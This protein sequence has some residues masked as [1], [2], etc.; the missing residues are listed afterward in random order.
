[1][2]GKTRGNIVAEAIRGSIE[3]IRH[4]AGS[5]PIDQLTALHWL[6]KTTQ[7]V[8]DGLKDA[9]RQDALS[10]L[11][12]DQKVSLTGHLGTT[13]VVFMRP[14]IKLTPSAKVEQ[15]REIL[16][17]QF[18]EFFKVV[19]EKIEPVGGFSDVLD[20]YDG[21]KAI[22]DLLDAAVT[23]KE[24]PARVSPPRPPKV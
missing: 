20:E 15:L 7:A 12:D 21:P 5:Q 4:Q 11:K 19:P 14:A 8:L 9:A 3:A 13:Q 6:V 22:R 24:R 17:D 10:Q 16:G 1:M 2:T 18:L 23:F